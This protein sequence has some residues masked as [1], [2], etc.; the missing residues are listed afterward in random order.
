MKRRLVSS[1]LVAACLLGAGLVGSPP[2][3]AADFDYALQPRRLAPEVLAFIGQTADFDTVNGG[4]IVNTAVIDSPAGLIVIDSGPSL[5][6]GQQLRARFGGR[7]VALVINTHLHPDHMLGNLAYADAPIGALPATIDGMASEGNAFAENLYRMSGDWMKGTE[8]RLPDR[9][10]AAGQLSVAG[11]RLQLLALAGHSG[12]DLAVY[13]EKSG[14]LFAGDLVFHGR[15]PTTPHA[16]IPRW[17]AAL[18]ELEVLTRRPG[19]VAL[20]PGHGEPARDAGPIR[21]TRAWL[22]WLQQTVRDAARAGLDMNEVM[23][24]PLPAEFAALPMAATEFRRSVSHLF[25][26]AEAA[27][28][29]HVH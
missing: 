19:F 13:D 8:L 22:Q 18:D 23:A 12:A 6:Y 2:A 5:R 25:P 15:A 9:P 27:V 4:N 26:A 16:D 11:R 3:A 29:T 17:L 24:R 14:I 1:C 10:L 21:Q 28:L 7:P 20:L